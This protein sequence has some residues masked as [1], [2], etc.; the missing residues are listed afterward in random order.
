MGCTY[1]DFNKA[2]DRISNRVP[3]MVF[4]LRIFFWQTLSFIAQNSLNVSQGCKIGPFLFV[5]YV[6]G[7]YLFVKSQVLNYADD[8]KLFY[9]ITCDLHCDV[10]QSYQSAFFNWCKK[11]HFMI[12]ILKCSILT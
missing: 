7:I 12:N 1:T 5:L 4:R 11:Q 2:F 9:N 8:I 3:L 6:N 10:L